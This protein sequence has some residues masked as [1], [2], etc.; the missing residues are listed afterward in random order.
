MFQIG[1]NPYGFTHT[2]GLQAFSTPRANPDGTGIRG[3]IDIARGVGARCYEFDGR[4]LTP[5]SNDE[6]ARLADELPDLPR[7]CSYWLQQVPGETLDEPIRATRGIGA[8]TIRMHLTPVLEGARAKQGDRWQQMIAHARKTLNR[9]A[10]KAADA[11]LQVAIENHQDFGSDELMAFAEEAGPNVGIALDTGNPF[12]VAEDPVAFAKQVAPR[13]TH[14][15]LK[16]YVSQFTLEGFRLIRCAIGDGCVPLREI[17]DVLVRLKGEAGKG[18][19]LTA[20]IEVGALEARHVRVFAPDWWAGYPTR[21]V[22]ELRIAL[23]RLKMRRLDDNADYRTP[24]ELNE[25]TQ[26]IV[27][28]ELGQLRKSVENMKAL[29]WM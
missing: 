6:L 22:G 23:D 29:G 19:L 16:D 7:L 18:N 9:E 12:A 2:V 17:A 11:G 4:W 1:L 24:W 3:F 5:M 8:G 26:A 15:H 21:P 13:V 28:Y 10:R 25:S 27:D 20:S 14:V